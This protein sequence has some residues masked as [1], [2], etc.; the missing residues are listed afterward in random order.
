MFFRD[1]VICTLTCEIY[2]LCSLPF[3]GR[4]IF[5]FPLLWVHSSVT[6]THLHWRTVFSFCKPNNIILFKLVVFQKNFVVIISAVKMSCN[7]FHGIDLFGR[8][9]KFIHNIC[10]NATVW[11]KHSI[12][13]ARN[14]FSFAFDKGVELLKNEKSSRINLVWYLNEMIWMTS[15][16]V[17]QYHSALMVVGIMLTMITS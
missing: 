14:K 7:T 5:I 16:N 17:I 4:D 2:A 12:S 10:E 6:E 8:L 3:I 11:R 15:F 9:T 1:A 13:N